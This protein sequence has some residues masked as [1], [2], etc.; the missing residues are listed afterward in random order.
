MLGVGSPAWERHP[1]SELDA[2]DQKQVCL[3]ALSECLQEDEKVVMFIEHIL[4]GR[5]HRE[6]RLPVSQQA[7]V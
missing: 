3:F 6:R 1:V 2:V 4:R 5:S 7:M